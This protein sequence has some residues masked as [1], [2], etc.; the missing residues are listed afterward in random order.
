MNNI[1]HNLLDELMTHGIVTI[2]DYFSEEDKKNLNSLFGNLKDDM[3]KYRTTQNDIKSLS[4]QVFDFINK[5]EIHNLLKNYLQGEPYC[6]VVHLTNHQVKISEDETSEIKN[7]GVCAF[8]NDNC[9]KQ[10][11][12]NILLSDLEENSN[13]LDFAVGS[14]KLSFLDKILIKFLNIFSLF[15]GWDKHF[16]IYFIN[17][18]YHKIRQNFCYEKKIFKKYKIKKIFGKMGKIYIFDTNGFHRQSV[19][20]KLPAKLVDRKVL[21]LYFINKDKFYSYSNKIN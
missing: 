16:L 5:N 21:T 11:K 19:I 13:G 2:D 17:K 9:G 10:L 12:I 18:Y 6:T 15:K 14:H 7:S 20:K 1:D 4:T 8:H 3:I